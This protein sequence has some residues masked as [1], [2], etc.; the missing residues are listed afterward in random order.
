MLTFGPSFNGE[1]VGKPRKVSSSDIFMEDFSAG[2]DYLGTLEYVDRE[3]I[4]GIGI[5]GNGGFLLGA[6]I[7]DISIK[8]VI[9]VVM[10][11]IPNLN[12]NDNETDWNKT[13][14]N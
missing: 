6:A 13:I 9:T 7:I 12:K 8:A 11:D 3:K 1:S 10:Y 4:G 14:E 5:C 2:F